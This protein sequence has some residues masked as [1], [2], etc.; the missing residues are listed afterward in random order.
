MSKHLGDYDAAAVIY[1]KFT[2]F[3]PSTGA[4]FTLAGTPALS[5]YKDNSTTQ[6]TAGVTLTADFDAVTGLNHF[7]I[8]TSA[9]GTFYSAGS[10]FD[11]VITAGTVDGVSV[12]GSVVGSFT[13]RKG[14]ALKPTVAGRTLDVSA[15]GEA[16]LDWANIG[17][18]T[19]TQNLT[20][21][22]V[23]AQS[24][25]KKNQALANFPFVMTDSTTNL[26]ATGKTVSV[27]RSLDGGVSFTAVGTATE[28]ASGW[29]QIDFAAGDMNGDTV[30]L[31]CTATG[32][33]DKNI[34]IVTEP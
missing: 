4:A 26:P 10:N 21:T 30:A 29:Y 15:T 7:A 1:G 19:T 24:G 8:D 2:T 14:S 3:R 9:D 22:T 13:L 5:V 16:G 27:S 6:S 31:R 25:I 33:Y 12:V 20:G 32:C 23:K 34:T 17:A 11:L 28:M 18:P